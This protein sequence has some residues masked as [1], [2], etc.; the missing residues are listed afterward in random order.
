MHHALLY[1]GSP[2]I[3]Q[4]CT[5]G[6]QA[7]LGVADID[8]R[9]YEQE[10]FPI[11]DARTLVQNIQTTP[12]GGEKTLTV[13]AVEK[14][15]VEAQNALLKIAEEPPAHA[16]IALIVPSIDMLLPTLVSRF[17]LADSENIEEE[18]IANNFLQS[19]TS[20]RQKITEKI[21]KDKDVVA[22]KKLIR[23]LETVL[24]KVQNKEQYKN[25]IEDLMAFRQYVEQRGASMKFMLEHLALTLPQIK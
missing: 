4:S 7:D 23:D 21:V 20:A 3:C 11:A 6:L 15:D 10:K 18:S 8:I 2:N 12:L 24:A 25:E 17:V 13:V 14:I 16:H 9:T 5:R 1:I 19:S 22:G